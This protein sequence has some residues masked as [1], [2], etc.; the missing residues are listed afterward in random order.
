M[1][2]GQ[3]EIRVEKEGYRTTTLVLSKSL[4]GIFWGNIIIGGTLGSITDFA[5][6]AAYAYAPATYHVEMK[7]NGTSQ[8]EFER[9][10]TV[11]KFAMI[12]IDEISQDHTF[13][14]KVLLL[15][16]NLG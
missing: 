1:P 12:F 6:G 8:I 4:E 10:M 14:Q 2:K 5:T 13:H 9:R 16:C 11:R 15:L 7:A 3:Q